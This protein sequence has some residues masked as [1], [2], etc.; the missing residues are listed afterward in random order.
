MSGIK[1]HR[2]Q[3]ARDWCAQWL[4]SALLC[5]LLPGVSAATDEA[6]HELPVLPLVVTTVR[7]AQPEMTSTVVTVAWVMLTVASCLALTI[8]SNAT[9]APSV[10]TA[11]APQR[12]VPQSAPREHG[13]DPPGSNGGAVALTSAIIYAS[14]NAIAVH[15]CPSHP[16]RFW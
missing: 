4:L 1:A 2:R 9:V 13:G 15:R 8:S 12:R 11:A 16:R 5:V 10:A 3:V 14:N 6:T 7:A